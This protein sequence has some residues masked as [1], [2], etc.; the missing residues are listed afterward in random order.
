[1][2]IWDMNPGNP[3]LSQFCQ[4]NDVESDKTQE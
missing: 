3:L 4:D 1:M 2:H